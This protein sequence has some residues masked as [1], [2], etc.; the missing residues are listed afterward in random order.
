MDQPQRIDQRG[1]IVSTGPRKSPKRRELGL[2]ARRIELEQTASDVR[3]SVQTIDE[4][5][6]PGFA[7]TYRQDG[8]RP[9]PGR[10][11][12]CA[13]VRDCGWA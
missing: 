9:H 12:S 2:E 11:F 5:Y 10:N 13:N 3:R 1:P 7:V 4:R 8:E 6:S